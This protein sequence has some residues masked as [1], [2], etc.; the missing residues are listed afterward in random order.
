VD[1]GTALDQAPARELAD[2][3]HAEAL[4]HR[5][6]TAVVPLGE[7]N[8]LLGAKILEGERQP[9]PADLGRVA[10]APQR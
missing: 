9:G 8:D 4:H 6:G 3:A 2:E 5:A 7:G 1:A 10:L